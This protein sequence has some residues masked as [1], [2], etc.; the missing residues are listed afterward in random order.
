M[1]NERLQM[2]IWCGIKEAF[3][4]ESSLVLWLKE[5]ITLVSMELEDIQFME[6]S[7]KMKA[8]NSLIQSLASFQWQ[9]QEKIPTD[10]SSLLPLKL[11]PILTV[12]M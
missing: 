7:F 9:T 10:P 12:N 1:L 2:D 6:R 5:E 11:L 8:L 3:S 4:I